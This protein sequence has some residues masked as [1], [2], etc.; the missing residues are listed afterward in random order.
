MACSGSVSLELLYH[1]KPTVILYW[2]QRY[3]YWVATTLFMKIRFITLVN[4][5]ATDDPFLP[6]GAKYDPQRA[7]EPDVPFP[8]YLTYDDRSEEIAGYVLSWLTDEEE[9]EQ[10]VRCLSQLKAEHTSAGAS[11]TAADYILS[12]LPPTLP[13]AREHCFELGKVGQSDKIPA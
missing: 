8:E 10:R 11:S 12:K 6:R 1:T 2:I 13:S 4:L 5:L 7:S 3:A 9:Y